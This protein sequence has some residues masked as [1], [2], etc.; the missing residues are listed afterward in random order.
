M[1]L[2]ARVEDALCLVELRGFEPL[3]PCMPSR[4]PGRSAL[5]KPHITRHHSEAIVMIRSVSRGLMLLE[6][7]PHCCR[8]NDCEMRRSRGRGGGDLYRDAPVDGQV[9][10]G[11]TA[12]VCKAAK[13]SRATY[14]F[15]HRM[16][17]RFDKPSLVRRAR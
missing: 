15:K 8:P 11:R 16:I 5:A 13:T 17:S 7:L 6:M 9:A 10:A 1:A 12:A 4:N 3:T 14:R 2:R